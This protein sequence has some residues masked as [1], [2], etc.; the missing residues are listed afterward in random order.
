MNRKIFCKSG[1]SFDLVTDRLMPSVTDRLLIMYGIL[2]QHLFFVVT[3]VVYSRYWDFLTAGANIIFL[4]NWIMNIL[5]DKYL[6]TVFRVAKSYVTFMTHATCRLTAKN[7][8]QLRNPTLGNRVWATFISPSKAVFTVDELNWTD[9]TCYE[10]TQFHDASLVTRVSFTKLIGCRAAVRAMRFS[11]IQFCSVRPWTRLNET[12]ALKLTSWMLAV[13]PDRP[14]CST[15]SVRNTRLCHSISVWRLEPIPRVCTRTTSQL[16]AQISVAHIS[17]NVIETTNIL[18]V[19][20]TVSCFAEW[21]KRRHVDIRH[22][23]DDA[24]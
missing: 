9:L 8:D 13:H 23:T 3:V 17:V 11:S 7:R 10:L 12:D 20:P 5:P 6:K 16:L 19:W 1:P 21:S 14:A 22:Y 24:R 15:A 4:V 18:V 2:L